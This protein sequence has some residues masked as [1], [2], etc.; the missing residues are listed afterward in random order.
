MRYAVPISL[1]LQCSWWGQNVSNQVSPRI[2]QYLCS[3]WYTEVE[4]RQ[5]MGKALAH[6]LCK[7]TWSR[8]WWGLILKYI[9]TSLKALKNWPRRVCWTTPTSRVPN[10]V[11]LEPMIQYVVFVNGSPPYVRL[12]FTQLYSHDEWDHTFSNFCRSFIS[13]YHCEHNQNVKTGEAREWG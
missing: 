4:E 7:W 9:Y 13:M 2:N 5:Y 6:L 12:V 3:Q 1:S 10:A 11:E 8:H